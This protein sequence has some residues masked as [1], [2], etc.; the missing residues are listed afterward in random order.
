[1]SKHKQS[2]TNTKFDVKTNNNSV[3]LKNILS[4]FFSL[5]SF[6]K[7][8]DP[9]YY[10]DL[11]ILPILQK[12]FGKNQ[13]IEFIANLIYALICA[14]LFYTLLIFLFNSSSPLVIVYSASMHP[15][16]YRGDVIGLT[17][18]NSNAYFGEVVTLNK[19]INQIFAKDYVTG[20]YNSSSQLEKL[21]FDKN[22]AIT[23]NTNG[24]IV[25]YNSYPYGIP[26]IH[27]SIAQI[28]A[29][30]GNFL[31]TKG[32]N[33]ETNKQFD[34]DCVLDNQGKI[35]NCLTVYAINKKDIV[36]S[37]FFKIP[38]IGCIKLWIFDD[39]PALITTSKLPSDF[40]PYC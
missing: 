23:P 20:Q 29:L 21:V 26:I 7:Y 19:S 36:G 13:T 2:K 4:N 37:S 17:N 31:I 33:I 40:G 10:F 34:Q 39:L 22:I 18:N 15:T 28:V 35:H 1:M 5:F 38:L 8:I 30:D 32:D 12:I 27:R 24:Q 11:I 3:D 14:L 25:V 9:F 6:L 16:L